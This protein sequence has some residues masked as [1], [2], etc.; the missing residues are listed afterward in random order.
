MPDHLTFLLECRAGPTSDAVAAWL[1][2]ALLSRRALL[3]LSDEQPEHRELSNMPADIL[4]AICEILIPPALRIASWQ[5]LGPCLQRWTRCKVGKHPL[6]ALFQ[7]QSSW[8]GVGRLEAVRDGL[9]AGAQISSGPHEEKRTTWYHCRLEDLLAEDWDAPAS[10][11]YWPNCPAA[12]ASLQAYGFTGYE[13]CA[14]LSA[15]AGI[16]DAS[17]RCPGCERPWDH[18]RLHNGPAHRVF[19]QCQRTPCEHLVCGTCWL[20]AE[21]AAYQ[22]RSS[23]PACP[24]CGTRVEDENGVVGLNANEAEAF[25]GSKVATQ[26]REWLHAHPKYP[27]RSDER[28]SWLDG[29]TFAPLAHGS[30]MSRRDIAS[31]RVR[32][33]CSDDSGIGELGS[34]ADTHGVCASRLRILIMDPYRAQGSRSKVR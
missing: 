18:A 27:P 2:L 12:L 30:C 21:L 24:A 29:E 28:D 4:L 11:S 20:D 19:E 22:E 6:P 7:K 3:P 5:A 10:R 15:V 33:E 32:T 25:L 17:M 1:L 9:P 14:A 23:R 8:P 34:L 26:A 31:A 13:S 16:G